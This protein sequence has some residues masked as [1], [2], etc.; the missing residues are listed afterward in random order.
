MPGS[1][2]VHARDVE[3]DLD[4]LLKTGPCRDTFI[5]F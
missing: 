4:I 2:G 5:S 3:V 1:Y